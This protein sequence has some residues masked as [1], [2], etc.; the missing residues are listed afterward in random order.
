M[1]ARG[2]LSVVRLPRMAAVFAAAVTCVTLGGYTTESFA[3]TN[4][5]ASL[6]TMSAPREQD[7]S[8]LAVGAGRRRRPHRLTPGSPN[9]LGMRIGV[10]SSVIETLAKGIL[11]VALAS[12]KYGQHTVECRVSSSAVQLVQGNLEQAKVNG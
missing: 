12:P 6:Y 7:R 1:L 3:F 9:R 8:H 5:A 4:P 11:N 2:V 10:T